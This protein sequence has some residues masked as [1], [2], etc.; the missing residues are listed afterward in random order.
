MIKSL[1][2]DNFV[3]IEELE[4][5]FSDGLTIITGETGAGKSI[6]LGALGLIMGNRADT[7]AL[8]DETKKCVIE[9]VFYIEKYNL[10]EFFESY[11]IDY[12]NELLV[13]RELTPTGKSRAFIN[14]TPTN[15]KVLQAL[16]ASLIDLHQQF[17]TL[18]IHDNNF[19]LKMIDALAE[20]K[21]LLR[22]YQERFKT[23]K[24]DKRV[25][26]DLIQRNE[27]T[28]RELDFIQFQLE[29]FEEAKLEAG[30]Q[31]K[32]EEELS[33]LSNAEDIARTLG[34]AYQ[35]LTESEQAVINQLEDIG[36]SLNQVSRF[37]TQIKQ[38]YERYNSIVIELQ[39]LASEFEQVAE[40]TEFDPERIQTIQDRLDMIY[41]L[42][43]KHSVASVEEL[44]KIEEE[45]QQKYKV[46][47]NMGVEIES[48]EKQI[49]AHE[50]ELKAISERLRASRLGVFE[51]FE[52]KVVSTLAELSMQHAQL[53]VNSVPTTELGPYGMDEVNFLFA[54][55]KGGR[56][57][58][59]REVASGGE[60]SRL[61]LVTKSLVASSIPLPTMIF[62][63]IDTGISG[64]VAL[65]MGNILRKLSD[66][67]QVISITHSPQI[68]SKADR[69][70]F[71]YKEVKGD[72]TVTN[73]KLLTL[74]ERIK[75]IAIML[76]QHPPSLSAI[77]NARELL[78]NALLE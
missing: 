38:L 50:V 31:E 24:A 42:Q 34:G 78:K 33:R 27:N 72:R 37:S 53:K 68:A 44:L 62:D 54:A 12:D 22:T 36:T 10:K 29:E 26:E 43:T 56:L 47:S 4:I 55:N 69:H 28:A 77:E 66:E 13:R 67:H 14:D 51:P 76:S 48:L 16:S 58:E 32:L 39:D 64:D 71:V 2:I 52:Q 45:L 75:N 74:E 49:E 8:Y 15:L 11:D 30:E 5:E 19:Q 41:R 20:N 57:Q 35:F 21:P 1:R 18:D 70:F 61:A 63:E 60:M 46:Y 17:D 7:K 59:I 40:E 23:Y 65:K 25:L 3:L 73:T 6:L 9:A